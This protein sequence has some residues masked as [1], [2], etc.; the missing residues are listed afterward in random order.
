MVDGQQQPIAA[1]RP[2]M[3][4]TDEHITYVMSHDDHATASAA[5]GRGWLRDHPLLT[6][7]VA[8]TAAYLYGSLPVVYL[9]GQRRA[10]DLRRVGSG[11]VGATNLMA[12]GARV[13][14]VVGWIFDASKGYVPTAACRRLGLSETVA[15]VAGIC[16]V[17]GQC[18]PIFL[19]FR[20][21]RGISA[22]VGA[23]ALLV[24]RTGWAM[25]LAPLA[26]GGLWRVVARQLGA[27]SGATSRTRSVPFGCFLGMVAFPVIA[28]WRAR[29]AAPA[30]ADESGQ[31]QKNSGFS[32]RGMLLAPSILS[33][34]VL[35]RRLTAPL[36][37]D[38]IVGPRRHPKAL[39]YRLL[40]DRN[41][42]E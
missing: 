16:G 37:D 2:R 18:W 32:A 25:T 35:F 34:V 5:S 14:S 39:L 30:R 31:R 27:S 10:L 13:L 24:D 7:V 41:T 19:R 4:G 17:A 8:W 6:G 38:A 21:G 42:S 29:I 1:V 26:G 40:Y 3:V 9:L 28:R 20:G 33:A 22:F 11:N 15:A 36:P 12:G 23:S